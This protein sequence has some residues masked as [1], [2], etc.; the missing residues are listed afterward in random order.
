M[1]EVYTFGVVPGDLATRV[2]GFV[3]NTTTRPTFDEV[4]ATIY[5]EAGIW[6]GFLIG[7]GIN[8]GAFTAETTSVCYTASRQYIMDRAAARV[9]RAKDRTAMELADVYDRRA[10][11]TRKMLQT[12]PQGF[13]AARPTGIDA[14]NLT[15]VSP[16]TDPLVLTAYR[17]NGT[18]SQRSAATNRM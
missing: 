3:A 12:N 5:E 2:G 17:N 11:D 4:E 14:P 9:L 7:M 8:P 6:C 18:V 15:Y 10:E 1:A 16:I 13:G